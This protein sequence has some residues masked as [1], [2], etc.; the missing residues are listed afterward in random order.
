[1]RMRYG[2]TTGSCAAAASKAAAYM[3]L[4]GKKKETISIVT[5]KGIV[6]EAKL[7]EITRK[8][9]S[10]SCA[11]EKD[12]GDDPDIT[13]GALV[14]A[15]VSYTERSKTSQTETSLQEEKQTETKALHAT[16]E[17]DGGIGV[18]RVTRPGMDQPVG[19]AAI[20]HV[21]RQMIEAEVLEVCRMADYKG[22]LKVI[23][24]IPK[25]VELAEKTFNPRLG[26]VGGIS[27]LGTSGVVEP[28][29][30]QALLDTIRLELNMRHAQNSQI[31]AVSPG[32]YGLDFM[33]ETYGYDL[34]AS[35]KCSNFIGETIDM[36]VECGFEKML[37]TGHIGKLVKVSGGIMNT[38]SR[39]ADCRVELLVAAGLRAGVSRDNLMKILYSATTTEAIAYLEEEKKTKPV[40]DYLM[41]RIIYYTNKRAGGKMKIECIL[42]DN[43][44]G[45]LAKSEGAEEF[46]HELQHENVTANGTT[47]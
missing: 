18:G 6:F 41:E 32:N 38:H 37:L 31:A 21:P 3:L 4:T 7:L 8:E 46:L 19:N 36:A 47:I 24:S 34:D 13:T 5:P 20:N 1:M 17:I 16:I 12:G 42:Y 22:A 43:Q 25:G 45:E 30:S 27:V 33:K 26:I 35:V 23:I 15:E 28:M 11:V 2:F 44:Y 9:K 10:V 40:M 29:S 14:Y 39:E